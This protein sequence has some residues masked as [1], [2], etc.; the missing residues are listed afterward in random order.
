V[1]D[2]STEP[3]APPAP[4]VAQLPEAPAAPLPPPPTVPYVPP[5][6]MN[7]N[8]GPRPR[9]LLGPIYWTY[10]VVLWAYVV[11]GQYTTDVAPWTSRD[12]PL[13]GGAAALLFI[14]CGA[15]ALWRSIAV[16]SP[17]P[18]RY[19]NAV[20]ALV[21]FVVTILL[22]CSSLLIVCMLVGISGANSDVPFRLL[23]FVA[24]LVALFFGRKWSRPQ[25][26]KLPREQRALV[27]TLWVGAVLA[28]LPALFHD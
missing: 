16:S 24:S 21:T 20:R 19:P 26:I 17:L 6:Q 7:F 11:L 9:P 10:G 23:L 12:V 8:P 13:G 4:E 5:E 1:S 2:E 3:E 18:S 25:G 14:L 28:S 15:L 22:W 27:I